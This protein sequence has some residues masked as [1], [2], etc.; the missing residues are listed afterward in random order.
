MRFFKSPFTY[1]GNKYSLLEEI[2]PLLPKE[3]NNFYDCFGGS[4]VVALNALIRANKVYYNELD[5]QIYNLFKYLT[6]RSTPEVI[7]KAAATIEKYNIKKSDDKPEVLNFNAFVNYLNDSVFPYEIPPTEMGSDYYLNLNMAALMLIVKVFSF[8]GTFRLTNKGKI[9][10]VFG[11]NTGKKW[12][13]TK[14]DIKRLT[15]LP[16]GN[17][18]Y[19]NKDFTEAVKDAKA[20]DFVYLDPPYF[21]TTIGYNE[22]WSVDM[23]D[24]LFKL[25]DDLHNRGVYWGMSNSLI[26]KHGVHNQNLKAFSEKY[27]IY[28]FDKTYN[29]F[30]STN[31][32][33]V[34]IYVT[35]YKKA[36]PAE[37]QAT[38]FD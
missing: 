4:G 37:Q 35:N 3:I 13:E 28:Y 12:E 21:E 19:T 11:W 20:G 10:V 22:S 8:H 32:A 16:L 2:L 33:N 6:V 34:E 27:N 5:F 1:H 29:A 30:G 9:S 18:K 24:K 17:L 26:S 14:E 38:I 23:D 36:P 15:L 25:L 31:K 7:K